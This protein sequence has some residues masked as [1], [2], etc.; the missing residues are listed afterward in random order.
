M[1]RARRRFG[2]SR[3]AERQR[4][5]GDARAFERDAVAQRVVG[6]RQVA[7]DVVRQRVHAGRRGD[8]AA[9]GRASARDRRRPRFARTRREHDA[10]DV[11]VVLAERRSS[12]RPPSRCPRSSAARRSRAGA[13]GDRAHLRVV[14]R[15]LDARRRRASPSRRR[16]WRRRAPRRRR[17]RSRCRRGARGRPPTPCLDLRRRRVAEN[18]V[19]HARHRGPRL[20][21]E[22]VDELG[23]HRRRRERAVGDDQR[24]LEALARA[25]ARATSLRRRRRS[26]WWSETRSA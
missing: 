11:R 5:R 1:S 16:P 18:A 10:L 3:T 4:T 14:P 12:G 26:G 22:R 23:E 19:E 6:R 17:S 2:R 9:A 13:I 15:V 25:G 20:R 7:L 21:L 8:R 24:P